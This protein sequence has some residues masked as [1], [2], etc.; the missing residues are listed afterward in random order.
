MRK[1]VFIAT[2]LMAVWLM[3]S[4]GGNNAGKRA[5]D[6]VDSAKEINEVTKPVDEKSAEFAVK[7]AAGGLMEV[8]MGKLAQEKATNPRV[9]NFAAMM[10]TDHTKANDELK[11]LASQKGIT[12]PGTLDEDAQK[13]IDE[14]NKKTGKDFDKE[15]MKMMTYVHKDNEHFFEK[16]AGDLQDADLKG[17]AG[18]V[19]PIIKTH[20]DS[21]HVIRDAVK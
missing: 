5:D 16:A 21:A 18:K 17:F 1:T 7:A 11:M 20:L 12:L 10:V 13:H 3:Q 2:A 6:S 4:C 15:Y 19:Y 14:L 8:E 9:K